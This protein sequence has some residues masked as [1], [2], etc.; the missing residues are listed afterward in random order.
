[1]GG[2]GWCDLAERWRALGHGLANLNQLLM[3]PFTAIP[4]Y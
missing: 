1:M 4:Q 2:Q 3:Q